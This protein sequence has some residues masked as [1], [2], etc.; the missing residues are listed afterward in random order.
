MQFSMLY[1]GEQILSFKVYLVFYAGDSLRNQNNI[2]IRF[3]RTELFSYHVT[4]LFVDV[5]SRGRAV[6]NI[7][8]IYGPTPL[9][10]CTYKGC[11]RISLY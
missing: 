5:I 8:R 3:C 6:P 4:T 9:H 10:T 11:N 2:A 1:S 7:G